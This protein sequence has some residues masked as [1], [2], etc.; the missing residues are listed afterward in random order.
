MICFFAI[1]LFAVTCIQFNPVDD[2]FFIS[3]SLDEKVRIWNVR[4]RKIEDW[5]DL[6]EMVTAACYS[7]DGQVDVVPFW[8]IFLFTIKLEMLTFQSLLSLKVALVGSHK[9]GCHIYDTS[10]M[11]VL[12]LHIPTHVHLFFF[13]VY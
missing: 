10:G 13:N 6:H 3:G 2:N 7:P 4:D 8:Y 1:N 5:N 11:A 9:G 12:L